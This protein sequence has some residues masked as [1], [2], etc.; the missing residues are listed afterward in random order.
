MTPRTPAQMPSGWLPLVRVG[1]PEGL[2]A[3]V[4]KMAGLYRHSPTRPQQRVQ[5]KR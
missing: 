4:A 5:V 1:V 2:W 3:L